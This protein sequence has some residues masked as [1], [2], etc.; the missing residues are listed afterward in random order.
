MEVDEKITIFHLYRKDGT[1]LFLHPFD[2][3]EKLIQILK[4]TR[5][6]GKY[7][8]E[9]RVESLTLFRNDLYR[10]IEEAVRSWVAERRFIPRFIISAGV[11]LLAYLFLSFVVRDPLPLVDEILI[12][13]AAS[14]GAY[15]LMSRRDQRS[16][17]A[18]EKR[19]ELKAAVD[20]IVFSEDAF[21][22]QVEEL[23]QQH[24]TEPKERLFAELLDR[25]RERLLDIA[26]ESVAQELLSYLEKRFNT[27]EYR[28][29]ERL[30][31]RLQDRNENG[32]HLESLSKWSEAKKIDLSLFTVYRRV[33]RSCG[34]V[35]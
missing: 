7:G 29:Q 25:E 30:L 2:S 20:R 23:L 5:I 10:L 14:V 18:L 32:R 24:D 12:G 21:V 11:F 6:V 34:S 22:R 1:A 27:K 31:S 16:N 15:I 9:P 28:K 17:P 13:V 26:D 19:A 4:R 35:K 3:L 8:T 33:K